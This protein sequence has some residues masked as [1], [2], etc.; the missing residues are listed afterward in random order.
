[1]I[2]PTACNGPS[3]DTSVFTLI[4][5]RI[6]D[7]IGQNYQNI[8]DVLVNHQN[9]DDVQVRH[10]WDWPEVQRFVDVLKSLTNPKNDQTMTLANQ[11]AYL[12]RKCLE[13]KWHEN[14][15][16]LIK[17]S[18]A[19]CQDAMNRGDEPACVHCSCPAEL[20]T[21]MHDPPTLLT[22]LLLRIKDTNIH[23]VRDAWDLPECQAIVNALETLT[24]LED[25]G[26]K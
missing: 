3:L 19:F 17:D 24:H 15:Q 16:V 4:V 20:C 25:G 18:C 13:H 11:R 21:G 8:D 14:S 26:A 5:N 6:T 2:P 12:A 10:V 9:L 7:E 1:M 22:H 23:M